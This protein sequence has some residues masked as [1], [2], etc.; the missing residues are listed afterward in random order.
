MTAE[1][2]GF[3][4]RQGADKLATY[5]F[6]TAAAEHHF[7]TEC[8]IYTHHKRRSNPDQLGVNAACLTGVSPFDFTEVIVNDGIN[9][10]K[11]RADGRTLI[12]G[13]LRFEPATN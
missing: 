6:N 10:P 9:H 3:E 7:C 12:A 8:G 11:D 2:D 4:L 1:I 13:V 5:R